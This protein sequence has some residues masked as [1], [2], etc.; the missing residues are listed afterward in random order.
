[1]LGVPKKD[2]GMPRLLEAFPLNDQKNPQ[3]KTLLNAAVFI[4]DWDRKDIIS[5]EGLAALFS[6]TDAE[7]EVC[8]L[9]TNGFRVNEVAEESNTTIETTHSQIK[10]L[11]SKTDT[12]S[13]SDL[14]RLALKVNLP[15][16]RAET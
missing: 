2:G 13:Q 6:L 4:R 11:F 9:L 12:T 14:V 1:M 7:N 15:V 16:N 10:T 5:T 8:E 3:Q